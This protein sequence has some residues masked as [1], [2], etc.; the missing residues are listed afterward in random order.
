MNSRTDF[1][2]FRIISGMTLLLAACNET[3]PVQQKSAEQPKVQAYQQQSPD[4][5][6]DSAY[7]F[8]KKQ[9]D[10]GPRV[11]N[12]PAHRACG[13]W[14]MKKLKQYGA[15]VIEQKMTLDSKGTKLDARNII[16][17]INPSA[18]KRILLCA[19][20]D[21]RQMADKDTKDKD[22]PIDGA[23]DGASGVS[24]LLEIARQLQAKPL[25]IGVD[26]IFFDAE[27]RGLN[28]ESN[29]WCLGSAY[30]SKHVHDPS[31]KAKYGILLD[32][33]GAGGARFAWEGFST[34]HAKPVLEK[35][36]STAQQLGYGD[37]F[38][39]YQFGG[40]EDDHYYVITNTGLP[41]IDIINYDPESNQFAP[42]HHTHYDNMQIIQRSTLKAVGQTVLE[43]LWKE[44][45]AD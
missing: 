41:M 40:I 17:V 3:P 31:Y 26:I 44:N 4:F 35:V 36:W 30:W 9:V 22:K 15:Q 14:M 5:N 7:A 34:E 43:V 20:W 25:N 39:Y 12:T 6:A 21:T 32:M 27:D 45:Q 37:K 11:N 18:T 24:V 29:T 28:N 38:L 33:V 23:D 10:F 42:H 16:G 19:H 1:F 8:V 2:R 13:D